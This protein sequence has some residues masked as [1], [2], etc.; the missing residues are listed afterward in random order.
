MSTDRMI[1]ERLSTGAQTY[2]NELLLALR[3]H[4]VPGPRIAEALAEVH[5]H[6]GE[7]G[8]DPREAFGPP[9]AYASELS[10]ALGGP[11]VAT[12]LWRSA[13]SWSALAYGLGGAVGA[14]LALDGVLALSTGERGSLGVPPVAA[15]LA[16]LAVLAVLALAFARLARAP[17]ARVLDPRDGADMA[18]PLPRWALPVMVAP[19][20]LAL[21]AVVV[22]TVA[23]QR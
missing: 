6:V 14:W 21:V 5:S 20:V 19:P 1:T 4:D 23:A 3:M 10:A 8:E 11:A 9:E 18:P 2:S 15:L 17:G 16:G 12:P 22:V 7:T 13:F